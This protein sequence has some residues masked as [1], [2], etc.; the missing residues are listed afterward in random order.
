MCVTCEIPIN[1]DLKFSV[2]PGYNIYCELCNCSVLS[3]FPRRA[4][5]LGLDEHCF[6]CFDIDSF[7]C[8]HC[9]HIIRYGRSPCNNSGFSLE[10]K[11]EKVRKV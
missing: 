6:H 3:M 2:L 1:I 10:L 11:H 7:N 9:G 5:H 4:I 8:P